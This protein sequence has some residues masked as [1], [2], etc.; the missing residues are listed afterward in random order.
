MFTVSLFAT[1]L[2]ELVAQN[3]LPIDGGE[4][5]K[6]VKPISIDRIRCLKAM[7]K[8]LRLMYELHSITLKRELF[9]HI[10]FIIAAN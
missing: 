10:H 1:L 8:E 6:H 3:L 4:R 5:Q 9:N 2:R 7:E